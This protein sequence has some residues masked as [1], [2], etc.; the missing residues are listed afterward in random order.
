LTPEGF[1]IGEPGQPSQMTP[2]GA[3]QVAN[4]SLAKIP[5]PPGGKR[6][7]LMPLGG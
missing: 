6:L 7:K 4:L 2:V 5:C 3:G 1:L